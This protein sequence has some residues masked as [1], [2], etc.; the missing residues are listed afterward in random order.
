MSVIFS[1]RR[2][3]LLKTITFINKFATDTATIMKGWCCT[4]KKFM[5]VKKLVELFGKVDGLKVLSFGG[6][7]LGIIASLM[8]SLAQKKATD[9]TIKAEVEKAIHRYHEENGGVL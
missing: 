1:H 4:M 9:Q 8:S 5:V 2:L 6:T 7:L 3:I